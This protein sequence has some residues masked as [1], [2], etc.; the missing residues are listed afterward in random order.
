M[1]I[2][3]ITLTEGDLY[4]IGDTIHKVTREVLQEAMTEKQNVLGAPRE[5]L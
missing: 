1:D 5:Q 2:E 4:D 3:P